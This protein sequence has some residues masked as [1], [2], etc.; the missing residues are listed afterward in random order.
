M[1]NED[2]D[3][4]STDELD[5]LDSDIDEDESDEDESDEDESD[6][7]ESDEDE[8][9]EEVETKPAKK[10]TAAAE[11]AAKKATA[12]AEKAAEKATAAAEKAAE[13]AALTAKEEIPDATKQNVFGDLRVLK[14]KKRSV[15]GP[16]ARAMRQKFAS[17][18]LVSI[19]LPID[20]SNSKKK[21]EEFQINTLYFVLP[22]GKTIQVPQ[23]VA[24]FVEQTVNRER[25]VH[26]ALLAA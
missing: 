19:V 15:E 6:E 17:D 7:D 9:D 25:P 18:P 14:R 12:A 21:I 5:D 24:R 13:K 3:L 10:A 22:L 11:K 2:K 8:S 1:K 4:D 16:K 20:L 23:C 26:D